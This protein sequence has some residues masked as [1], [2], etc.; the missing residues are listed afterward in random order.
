MKRI[1]TI[2][3][4]LVLCLSVQA[5][6]RI[7][8]GKDSQLRKLQWAEMAISNL[9]VDTVDESAL[10]ENAIRGML[11]KLDPHSTYLNA[12]E[13]RQT[14]ES[15]GGSFDGIGV[16]FNMVQDTLVVL[17]TIVNGP[18]EKV[19]ILAGDRIVNVNGE[20][21]AGV[22]MDRDSI[23][24]RLRGPRGTK[25]NLG[26]IRRGIPDM[27]LFTVTRDRIPVTT[28]DASYMIRPHVGYVRIG[29]FGRTTHDELMAGLDS[30]SRQ[31]MKTLILDLQENGGGYLQAAIDIANEFLKKGDLIVYTEGRR[32][33]RQD[34]RADGK[35]KYQGLKLYVLVNEY[36]ASASEIVSG[37]MQDQD[38]AV[39]VGRRTF[40]KGLVQ[41][42]I[43]FP[44]GS[45]I[46]LT[47]AHY[48]RPRA[49]AYR[50]L[51]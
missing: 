48:T 18:S 40:G 4:A 10:V 1:T 39:I 49:A 33:D 28:I 2:L 5:Q 11:E 50:S 44:D 15:L 7:N 22:K 27:L 31:G 25:A 37:A 26:I 32:A 41:R 9:Y 35:G 24:N 43:P 20:V 12:K 16:Q 17:Q 23:V 21:I 19:G 46:R 30:L 47:T 29:S 42:P 51:T 38:R 36:S 45:V 6:M 14:T 3:F 8:L 34:F 13:T